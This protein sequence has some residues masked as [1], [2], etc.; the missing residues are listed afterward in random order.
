MVGIRLIDHRRSRFQLLYDDRPFFSSDPGSRRCSFHAVHHL[1]VVLHVHLVLGLGGSQHFVQVASAAQVSVLDGGVSQQLGH[2]VDVRTLA[3][4][5]QQ[6]QQLIQCARIVA[7]MADHGMQAGQQFG[8]VRRQQAIGIPGI[9]VERLVILAEAGA[10]LRQQKQTLGIV[11]H[12]E[13]LLRDGGGLGRVPGLQVGL[14]QSAQTFGMRVEVGSLLQVPDG[15]LRIVALEGGLPAQQ[16]NVA[17]A[18]IE[19]QH[20][21]Q[22]VF[23]GGERS[24]RAQRFRRRAENF[25]RL[26]LFS[27]PDINLGEF[28]PHRHIFRVHFEDLL[29]K[30]H[31]LVEVAILH[32]VFGDLQVL[33]AG[34]VEQPLLGVE[35][36]QFQS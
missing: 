20:P 11:V 8:R 5:V 15:A 28:D 33:G 21:L 26:F 35:F 10:P 13:Q 12:R 3:G 27:Q 31:G 4:L 16:Q 19:H 7:H 30:A 9:N 1:L 6:Q 22:N 29:E 17:V 23:C 18:G 34:V 25:P 32:E 36:R 14:Q 24:T 2:F